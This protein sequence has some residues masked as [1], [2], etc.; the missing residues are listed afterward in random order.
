M[1][2]SVIRS[3]RPLRRAVLR[4]A[5]LVLVAVRGARIWELRT[6]STTTPRRG[7][8]GR[9]L[10]RARRVRIVGEQEPIQRSRERRA[11]ARVCPAR[12][13]KKASG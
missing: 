5:S 10:R 9:S 3:D 13:K 7:V 6:A 12:T 11:H 4:N 8:S 1:V 2:D